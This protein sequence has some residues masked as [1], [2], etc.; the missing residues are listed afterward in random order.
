M[1][2]VT[3]TLVALMGLYEEVGAAA[4]RPLGLKKTVSV[5]MATDPST[6]VSSITFLLPYRHHGSKSKYH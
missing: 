6:C 1:K 2:N 3:P 4:A 5:T